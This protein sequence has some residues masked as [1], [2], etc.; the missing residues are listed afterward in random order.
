[1]KIT[2]Q[3]TKDDYRH[4]LI[5]WRNMRLST[6]WSFRIFEIGSCLLIVFSVILIV[7]H[8]ASSNLTSQIEGI[9]I[10]AV[11]LFFIWGYPWVSAR[12]QF[13]ST[14][15]AQQP[16]TIEATDSGLH[17]QSVHADSQV[18]WSTYVGWKE[19]KSVFIILPQPRIYVPIPKRAFSI[20]QLAEFREILRR[21]VGKK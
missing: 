14:P 6:R 13:R 9:G 18:A 20:E 11:W 5:A 10:G 4:G 15:S 12:R 17:I 21:N 1:M 8:P 3:L 7:L 2:Y 16:M 19:E